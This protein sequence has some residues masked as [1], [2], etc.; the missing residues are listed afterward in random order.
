MTAHA[1]ANL[2]LNQGTI[3]KV[4]LFLIEKYVPFYIT[5]N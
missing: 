2:Q 3:K 4:G 1:Y 5:L